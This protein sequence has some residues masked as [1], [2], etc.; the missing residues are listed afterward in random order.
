MVKN[1][2]KGR[3][4]EVKVMHFA[5]AFNSIILISIILVLVVKHAQSNAKS[6]AIS[7]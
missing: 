5:Y 6:H 2:P 4:F 1:Q 7:R 3:I